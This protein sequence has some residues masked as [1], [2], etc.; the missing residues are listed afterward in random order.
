[1]REFSPEMTQTDQRLGNLM[2]SYGIQFIPPCLLLS[3]PGFSRNSLFLTIIVFSSFSCGFLL[4]GFLGLQRREL[5]HASEGFALTIRDRALPVPVMALGTGIAALL[6]LAGS[7][8]ASLLP[9]GVIL[10]FLAWLGRFLLSF[11]KPA[12]QADFTLPGRRAGPSF[13]NMAAFMPEAE[14]T[15]PWVGW[16]YIK[17]GFIVFLALLFLYF[18]IHPLLKRTGFSLKAGL[19]VIVRWAGDLKKGIL[20]FFSAF[21]GRGAALK[22][23]DREK[24]RHIA[25]QLLSGPVK[26]KDKRSVNLFARLVLWGVESLA[27]PWKPSL[28]PGEYCG[29][30]VVAA[31]NEYR[32][33]ILRSGDLFEKA[34]YSPLHLTGAEEKEFRF[35][36]QKIT[37]LK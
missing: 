31:V 1:M 18:M 3:A 16:K 15:V 37:G 23:P 6:A 36:V 10:E 24:L 32:K 22:M 28:A 4:L 14:E 25:S 12:E 9:P 30:L 34:L 8:D 33:A 5:T 29:L 13:G 26:R 21:R 20:A 7:S 35:L 2:L 19:A 27:V 17:Y 11:F